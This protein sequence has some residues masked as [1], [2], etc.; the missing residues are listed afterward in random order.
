MAF[1][2]NEYSL[3]TFYLLSLLKVNSFKTRIDSHHSSYFL[4]VNLLILKKEKKPY[5]TI[6]KRTTGLSSSGRTCISL[7]TNIEN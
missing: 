5:E 7:N 6:L 3:E 2:N 1:W 4:N